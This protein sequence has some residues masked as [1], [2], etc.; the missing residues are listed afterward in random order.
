MMNQTSKTE[1]V[2]VTLSREQWSILLYLAI[3]GG[4]E[5]LEFFVNGDGHTLECLTANGEALRALRELLNTDPD[6]EEDDDDDVPPKPGMVK[7]RRLYSQSSEWVTKEEAARRR[8][9]WDDESV[10]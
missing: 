6:D 7:I 9:A 10:H 3:R 2:S 1:P 4:K 5:A 8:K